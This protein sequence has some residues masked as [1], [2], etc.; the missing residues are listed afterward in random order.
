MVLV[1]FSVIGLRYNF[2]RFIANHSIINIHRATLPQM[3]Q[4]WLRKHFTSHVNVSFPEIWRSVL[5]TACQ[6]LTIL[7]QHQVTTGQSWEWANK[8][9]CSNLKC[10]FI[11]LKSLLL[12][13]H[14][15]LH[16]SWQHVFQKERNNCFYAKTCFCHI[17]KGV[18]SWKFK[19][20][21]GIIN[22]HFQTNLSFYIHTN[23]SL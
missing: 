17:V 11:S 15:H 12:K 22:K 8:T 19:E 14:N 13:K 23:L 9:F 6:G 18:T 3:N 4:H 20:F 7:Y 16:W 2:L 5:C 21:E 10:S 1:D